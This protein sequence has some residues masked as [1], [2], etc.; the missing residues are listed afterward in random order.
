MV[1]IK[2]AVDDINFNSSILRGTTLAVA[3]QDSNYNGFLDIVEAL[4][5]METHVVAIIGP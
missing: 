2:A 5:F 1:A 4:Q 3:M